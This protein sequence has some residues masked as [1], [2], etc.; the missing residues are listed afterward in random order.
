MCGEFGQSQEGTAPLLPAP[1]SGTNHYEMVDDGEK[2]TSLGGGVYEEV[3]KQDTHTDERT[4]HYH[5]LD[6]AKLERN[7]YATIKA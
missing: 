2:R 7:E 3:D 5:E 1:P 4:K 6:W